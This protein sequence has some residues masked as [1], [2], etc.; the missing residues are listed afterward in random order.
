MQVEVYGDG[1]SGRDDTCLPDIVEASWLAWTGP[2]AM[3]DY[4]KNTPTEIR[5]PRPRHFW[6]AIASILNF[7]SPQNSVKL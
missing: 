1:S 6:L 4:D 3:K 5:L 7:L 2:L